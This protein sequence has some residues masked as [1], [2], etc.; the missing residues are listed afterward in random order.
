MDNARYDLET[1]HDVVRLNFTQTV[2]ND[3]GMWTCDAIVRSERYIANNGK[4]ALEE[5]EVIGVPFQHYIQLTV[6]GECI[7]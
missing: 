6:V 7:A 4:L 2:I 1:G 3:T 5:Q